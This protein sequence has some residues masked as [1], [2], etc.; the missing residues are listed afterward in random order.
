MF[1]ENMNTQNAN[2]NVCKIK[3]IGVGG[4]GNNAVNRML[5]ENIQGAEFVAVNTDLQALMLSH[6]DPKNRLQIGKEKT[7][8]IV[9]CLLL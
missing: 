5:D 6:A 4:G 1:E 7:S 2:L 8:I 9:F 3:V